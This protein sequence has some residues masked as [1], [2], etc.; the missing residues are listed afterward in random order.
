[1]LSF[2]GGALLVTGSYTGLAAVIRFIGKIGAGCIGVIFTA[3]LND[4]A[5]DT[6]DDTGGGGNRITI[7]VSR[8]GQGPP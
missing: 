8:A 1:M 6:G 4:T 2:I 3:P 5:D 7:P